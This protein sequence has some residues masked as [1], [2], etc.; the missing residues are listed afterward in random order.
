[1]YRKININQWLEIAFLEPFDRINE[2]YFFDRTTNEFYSVFITDYFLIEAT[3]PEELQNNPYT[4]DELKT[5]KD[6]LNRQEINHPSIIQVPRLTVEERRG[7]L[8]SFLSEN[9]LHSKEYQNLV[10]AENGRTDLKFEDLLI[11]EI[12]NKWQAFKSDYVRHA[13]DTFCNINRIDVETVTLWT[14]NKMTSI[15]LDLNERSVN[16]IIP[17]KPWWRFW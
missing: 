12:Q 16:E 17:K 8:Q 6:R 1:M 5:L 9:K 10:E 13:V 2:T 3:S 15:S 11:G 14:D 7:L 4:T